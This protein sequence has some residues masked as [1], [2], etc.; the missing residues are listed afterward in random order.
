MN[1]HWKERYARQIM[2]PEVGIDGQK[3]LSEA[4]VL[5][6]GVGGLGSPL[7]L[8]LCAAGVGR[9]GLIDADV[10]SESN[11]QR[12]VLYTE[13]EV[14][15][16]K[17]EC[18]ARTLARHNSNCVIDT[19]PCFLTREN[20]EEIISRYDIVADGCDNFATRYLIDDLCA[21]LGKPYVYGSIMGL[22]GQVSVFNGG[23]ARRYQ[24]LYSDRIKLEARPK[25]A[26]G[27]MG[28]TPAVVG[29]MEAA[30]A[31]KIITGCGTPLYNRLYSIDLA[32]MEST[33]LDL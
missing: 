31:I 32:T 25:A 10:V 28:P 26:A 14:G 22:R 33:L 27:V 9:L 20:A 8:Y 4:S 29:S 30:E 21:R 1:E 5:V 15:Q 24:D 11:L 7:S 16:P 6:V 2:L 23:R 18:A 12:Q 3:A 13:A 19:Y 17:V